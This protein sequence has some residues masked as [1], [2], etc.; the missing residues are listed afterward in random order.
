[1]ATTKIE[2]YTTNYK[3]YTDGSTDGK[4]VNGGAGT[5]VEEAQGKEV[6][7]YEDPAGKLC[8]SYGGDS[9]LPSIAHAHGSRR[10]RSEWVR[11]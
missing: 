5:H 7:R 3:I 4:Q 8:S 2:S 10:K 6:A 9:V 11:R 1:M